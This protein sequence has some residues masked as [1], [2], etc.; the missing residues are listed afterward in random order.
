M[1]RGLVRPIR[2]YAPVRVYN[3]GPSPVVVFRDMTLGT[4]ERVEEEQTEFCRKIQ[5]EFPEGTI[6][7]MV[8]HT[9][10]EAKAGLAE[11]LRR[12]RKAF[13]LLPEE[14][15]R[16]A[17][18]QHKINTGTAP[19]IRQQPRRLA[20]HRRETV[21]S[22]LEKML[23]E[24]VIESGEGPWAAPVVLVKKK[25]GNVRFC[26]D[27]RK[28][29]EITIKDAYP[30][31][32]IDDSLD[33]LAGACCFSTLDL[34][35]GYWQVEMAKE[36]REKTAF[37]THRGLYQFKVM[38]FGL[39]N[40]PGTFERLMEITM[41]GLQ[42]RTCL[43]Y[44]DD[45]IVFAPTWELHMQR[46]DEVLTRIE[47]A[48]LRLKASKCFL[49]RPEVHF[50][51][52]VVSGTG[53]ATDP[54]KTRTVKEWPQPQDVHEVRSFLGLASYYRAFVQDFATLAKPLFALSEKNK[55]FLWSEECREAFE[56]LKEKLTTSPVLAYPMPEGEL[57]MDTDASDVGL[58]AVLSQTQAGEER[59]LSYASR[60]LDKP[61][62]NYC[63]TRR[64]MLAVIFGLRK[65]KHY[66]LGRK[67][68]IRTDH[69]SL[70]W[71]TQFKEPEG[72]VARWLEELSSYDF[73]VEHRPGKNHGNAD[74]LSRIPCRQ[75]GW[76]KETD[77]EL[78]RVL[79]S[80]GARTRS[81]SSGLVEEEGRDRDCEERYHSQGA[82]PKTSRRHPESSE[83]TPA[84]RVP[85]E[86]PEIQVGAAPTARVPGDQAGWRTAQESDPVLATVRE[87]VQGGGPPAD[88]GGEGYEM[89]SWASQY[90]RLEERDG[91]LGRTWSEPLGEERFQI[92]VPRSMRSLVLGEVHG[93]PLVSHFGQSRTQ[94]RLQ[95]E[96]YWPGYARDVILLCASWPQC[97]Q[98]E[99]PPR[100]NRA[101]MGHV[102]T[103][104]P[105]ERV[106]MEVMEG[107]TG[108]INT[109]W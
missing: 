32:R 30:L 64:E 48:G 79:R 94:R 39:C 37:A 102:R 61:E 107:L 82:R 96:F 34:A 86:G 76:G 65:F 60:T 33:T 36:D 75:C 49:A 10:G 83:Q 91:V 16:T 41:R 55:Q 35:S 12:H 50:L 27:Y 67:V 52:H 69:A 4:L 40:A 84:E 38:P 5:D 72:Q 68:R 71:V 90:E 104:L 66:L 24:G 21:E 80:E 8:S 6:D 73:Q 109:F 57:V 20:P 59:V 101:A 56:K 103:H 29:N 108:E 51:G 88:I 43:V 87:W 14:R 13:Q 44:L 47:S 93:P 81:Q 3:P 106:A 9:P 98:G 54:S 23:A 42:W 62:K 19:P 11:V 105:M 22:E 1:G 17:V 58:G 18:V 95:E 97:L 7:E 25:D 78:C 26:V 100:K 28:L 2:E 15:G 46:L 45:I 85:T 53:V 77:T 89:K 70:R 99:D 92:A 63:V 31:P 74:G